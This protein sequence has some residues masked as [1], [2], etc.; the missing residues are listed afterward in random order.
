MRSKFSTSSSKWGGKRYMP[1]AFTESGV[2]ML[3]TV[4]K[5][6]LATKQSKALIRT[7]KKMKDYIVENQSIIGSQ[8]LLALSI[9]ISHN[10]TQLSKHSK[11]ISEIKE[12]LVKNMVTKQDFKK[13]MEN[14]IDPNTYKH[15]LIM[16]G[17]KIEADV[18][19]SKIY[20]SAKKSIYVVDN[21]ISLK[22]LE[23]LRTAKNG[24]KIIIFSDNS[25]SRNMLTSAILEDFK[26]DYP[27]VDIAFK[28]TNGKCHDRYIVIDYDTKNESIYLSGA[29]S[30]DAGS[31]I[32][33]IMRIDDT[34]LYHLMFD[35]LLGNQKLNI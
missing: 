19:Y 22:T 23:L 35:E 12:N 4:L 9:Q 20:K 7:F 33:T 14:F 8:E 28:K 11:D 18:A 31:K 15:F 27:D 30:K 26:N 17:Q 6:D 1:F 32:T 25:R 13:V 34:K 21:Y 29:S 24:V 3:M 16:D 5:G 2:Y 10:T